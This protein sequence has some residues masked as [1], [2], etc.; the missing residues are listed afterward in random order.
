MELLSIDILHYFLFGF[1]CVAYVES[2]KP[3][4]TQFV[5]IESIL[6]MI[7]WPFFTSY[8]AYLKIIR[9]WKKRNF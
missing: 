9:G 7:L 5:L 8:Y 4:E 2:G 1:L 6:F 3:E